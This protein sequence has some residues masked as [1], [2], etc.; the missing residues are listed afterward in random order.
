M[1]QS[2]AHLV[3]A[4]K[5]SEV[6][7]RCQWHSGIRNWWHLACVELPQPDLCLPLYRRLHVH[8]KTHKCSLP[9]QRPDQWHA[10][11]SAKH[12]RGSLDQRM[13]RLHPWKQDGKR[14]SWLPLALPYRNRSRPAWTRA[15]SDFA[16]LVSRLWEPGHCHADWFPMLPVVKAASRYQLDQGQGER[17]PRKDH[18]H[19]SQLSR[20]QN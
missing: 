11:S 13:W 18:D 1:C 3:W 17:N 9:I 4:L 14:D 15:Q 10:L 19:D 2:V 6:Y 8:P 7:S 16:L 5:Q 12:M 20:D